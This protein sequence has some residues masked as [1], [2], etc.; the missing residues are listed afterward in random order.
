MWCYIRKRRGR[1]SGF[2]LDLGVERLKGRLGKYRWAGFGVIK[3]IGGPEIGVIKLGNSV[4]Y[5]GV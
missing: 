5:S 2:K 4:I 3:F 1:G